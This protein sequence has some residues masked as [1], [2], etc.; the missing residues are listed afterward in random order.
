MMSEYHQMVLLRNPCEQSLQVLTQEERNHEGYL[1]A[2]KGLDTGRVAHSIQ[3]RR[4]AAGRLVV[5]ETLS[6][7]LH[8]GPLYLC[9]SE[10]LPLP[11][12]TLQRSLQLT[13]EQTGGGHLHNC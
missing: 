6:H 9:L 5:A 2:S 1:K 12:I 11:F 7:N 3:V 10:H 4:G 8:I 13:G